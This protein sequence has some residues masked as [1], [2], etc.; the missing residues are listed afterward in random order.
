M[1]KKHEAKN[2]SH[3]PY[4]CGICFICFTVMDLGRR[5]HFCPKEAAR[6]VAEAPDLVRIAAFRYAQNIAKVNELD[7]RVDADV[8][9]RSRRNH[10]SE[11]YLERGGI[12]ENI[13]R[14]DV[15]VRNSQGVQVC[16][17]IDELIEDIDSLVRRHETVGSD[18]AI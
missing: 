15:T 7:L 4:V 10:Q 8:R 12:D 11:T 2:Q 18:V 1:T 9:F 3:R 14:F 6:I 16:H 5:E 13:P 17:S